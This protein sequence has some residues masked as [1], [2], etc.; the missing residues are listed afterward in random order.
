MGR[1]PE[2]PVAGS[3]LRRLWRHLW[4]DARHTRRL[5]DDAACARLEASIRASE[6]GH[7]GEIRLS[8][9]AALPPSYVWRRLSARD[10]ACTLFGKLQVWDTEHD[11]GVLVYVLLAEASIEIVADRGLRRVVP[12]AEWAVIVQ[13]MGERLAAGPRDGALEAA[14]QEAVRRLDLALRR[15]WPLPEDIT[16]PDPDELSNV[17]DRR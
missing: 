11:T 5:L 17:V 16:A 6:A 14:L 4:R 7:L 15:H 3:R 2:G 8:V 1:P 10:R 9:E 12:P 13:A